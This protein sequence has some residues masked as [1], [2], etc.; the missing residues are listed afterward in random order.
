MVGGPC[1]KTL[2][3]WV[4][5]VVLTMP[6]DS[7][8]GRDGSITQLSGLSVNAVLENVMSLPVPATKKPEVRRLAVM[9][10]VPPAKAT[11]LPRSMWTAMAVAVTVGV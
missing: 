8:L 6:A 10:T 1:T 2:T 4:V 9:L 7:S 3:V 11:P 5:A